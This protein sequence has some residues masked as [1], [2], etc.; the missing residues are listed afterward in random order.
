MS[1]ENGPKRK[2]ETILAAEEAMLRQQM[3]LNEIEVE[4]NKVAEAEAIA[5]ERL[6]T[7]HQR[8]IEEIKN[9]SAYSLIM[10][11]IEDPE[12]EV[13]LEGIWEIWRQNEEKDLGKA[14]D[15]KKNTSRFTRRF[16]KVPTPIIG[17][18]PFPGTEITD[19]PRPE[20][21][22]PQIIQKKVM[23]K[24]WGRSLEHT[25]EQLEL[26]LAQIQEL[27]WEFMRENKNAWVSIFLKAPQGAGAF[28]I[29][30]II[31]DINTH[32]SEVLNIRIRYMVDS[33]GRLGTTDIVQ[34]KHD[35]SGNKQDAKVFLARLL[36]NNGILI[37]DLF[38]LEKE[39]EKGNEPS[40]N[41]P[42]E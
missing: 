39:L 29:E 21:Y 36:A 22:V 27:Y 7:L 30:P 18:L 8:A 26:F 6:K 28:H 10:E 20:S 25:P 35:F 38:S 34:S 40:E 1:V 2:R 13:Y 15:K 12:W 19:F 23:Q 42:E 5:D 9:D 33:L 14:R 41:Q 17:E 16:V 3:Y 31:A 32:R 37:K 24:K 4:R 11:T